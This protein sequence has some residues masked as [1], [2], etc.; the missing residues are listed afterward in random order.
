M[1][2]VVLLTGR[3]GV[4]KTTLVRR[5]VER[6]GGRAGG[7]YTAEIRQGGVRRGFKLVTL[8]GHEA[9]IAH[10]DF[11]GR[12][13][14]SKYGV[15]VAALDAVGVPA[16]DRAIAAGQVVI[17]DEIGPMEL[18]S[19]AFRAAVLRAVDSGRPILATVARRPQPWADALKRRPGV[20]LVEITFA[21]RDALV[22]T[23]V[24]ELQ[25]SQHA[26]NP[27]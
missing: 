21:N 25:G 27:E 18:F 3:P 7:F 23:L 20:R 2:P 10:T 8:D 22:A 15:D 9:V 5:I 19:A 26:A 4:G 24:E 12:Q 13:R 6:L 14:V 17:I 16:I 11:A 1:S